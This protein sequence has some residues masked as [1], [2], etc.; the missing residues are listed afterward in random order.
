MRSY[1]ESNRFQAAGGG[2]GF[3]PVKEPD[4]ASSMERELRQGEQRD[5]TYYDSLAANDKTTIKNAQVAAES[6]NNNIET[7]L[8]A[9][10]Q[11][12][13]FAE[14]M[15]DDITRNKIVKD[16]Q[17]AAMQ[18]WADPIYAEK[19]TEAYDAEESKIEE[20]Q[21]IMDNAA[22]KY[23][24]DGGS[25]IIGE[26]LRT[27]FTGRNRLA[28]ERARMERLSYEFPSAYARQLNYINGTDDPG[29]RARREQAVINQFLTDT[30][31]IG[32]TPGM[33]NKYLMRNMRQVT[34]K[35]EASWIT[36]T[37]ESILNGRI[38]EADSELWTG[39]TSGNL[40]AAS[41]AYLEKL[42][43][44][45]LS[46][47]ERKKKLFEFLGADTNEIHLD[48]AKLA[49]LAGTPIDHPSCKPGSECTFGKV[50]GRE[51][52]QLEGLAAN[53]QDVA[54]SRAAETRSANQE[55]FENLFDQLKEK[56]EGDIPQNEIQMI[57]DKARKE[58]LDTDFLDNYET[59]ESY[60]LDSAKRR[61]ESIWQKQ[62]FITQN[63][64]KGMPSAVMQDS[65]VKK[66]MEDGS[67]RAG[68][69]Q[70]DTDAIETTVKRTAN[71]I[72]GLQSSDQIKG[73]E[74]DR[75]EN[76]VRKDINAQYMSNL[77]S[78]K[79]RNEGGTLNYGQA[80]NDA[81]ETVFQRSMKD[82]A[83]GGKDYTKIATPTDIAT[84]GSSRYQQ[85][86]RVYKNQMLND[87]SFITNNLF[88]SNAELDQA[89]K[90]L[91]NQGNYPA[92]YEDLAAGQ[93]NVTPY[94]IAM[95]QMEK[96][97]RKVEPQPVEVA[98]SQQSPELQRLLNFKPNVHRTERAFT[99]NMNDPSVSGI[100][101]LKMV[102]GGALK[103][104]TEDDYKWLAY[105][106]T[107]EAALGTDD[108]Y[109][110]AASIINRYADPT[111]NRGAKGI[112]DIIFASGQYEGVYKGMSR[113]DSGLTQRLMSPEGQSKIVQ[114]LR[115][116]KG[117]QDFKGQSQ[118]GNRDSANDPM[119]HSRGNFFH[120]TGQR[121]RGAWRGPVPTHYTRFIR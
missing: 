36:K 94:D 58:G 23:E 50:F 17:A 78:G 87:P 53:N 89:Q 121:S 102:E 116:L 14:G 15:A 103:G 47:L 5:R 45:G 92:S 98:V 13:K 20:G 57:K 60:S 25:P 77:K 95:A 54:L 48:D 4:I 8:K 24:E 59:A 3:N 66:W 6:L 56:Y 115:I 11:F 74:Y 108:E 44:L 117:R 38:D 7:N 35:A 9:L 49:D 71:E 114:M 64:L 85:R 41:S 34:S 68:E 21:G 65:D 61:L 73:I 30:G 109:M 10:G 96:S 40:G 83:E 55:N 111:W 97:G 79:Y 62:G 42:T 32:T 69:A 22:V 72:A 91:N 37:E 101:N 104:L 19:E 67:L 119:A 76:E 80:L 12:S 28:Y 63:D 70:S 1:E 33:L 110:V 31:A 82:P 99:P 18:A 43:N 52:D 118:L 93:V 81:R 16:A 46:P 86:I 90:A 26:Q 107:S 75:I 84:R 105:T 120:Y 27:S 113:H 2:G 106:L 51:L 112:K 88:S 100:V 29:E 39:L